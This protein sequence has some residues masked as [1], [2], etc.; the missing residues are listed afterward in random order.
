MKNSH[1]TAKIFML[2]VLNDIID[3]VAQVFLKKG[4]SFP[5]GGSVSIGGIYEFIVKN[6]SSPF[7]WL[8]LLIYMMNFFIWIVILYKVDLSIAMPVGSTS[9][10]FIPLAAV[11]FLHEHMSP[12]RWVGIICIVLG[13]HFVSQSKKT[14]KEKLKLDA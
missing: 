5:W 2:L 8:G 6:G 3:T 7:L 13:I 14:V 1:L 10:I 12:L 4:L 9:Y 11:F